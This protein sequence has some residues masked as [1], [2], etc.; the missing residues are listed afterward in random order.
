MNRRDFLKTT[1][2]TTGALMLAPALSAAVPA[3][4]PRGA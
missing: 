1:L 2:M 3:G 4:T